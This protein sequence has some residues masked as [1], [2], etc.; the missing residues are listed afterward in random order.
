M[1]K[2]LVISV[3]FDSI[4]QAK[5]NFIKLHCGK[6]NYSNIITHP[7]FTCYTTSSGKSY[8]DVLAAFQGLDN[9]ENLYLRYDALAIERLEQAKIS[10][11]DLQQ[12][13]QNHELKH[14]TSIDTA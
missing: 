10:K 2:I 1:S 7:F 11:R 13:S 5:N 12:F 9:K 8:L 3:R 4:S 6:N 14:I